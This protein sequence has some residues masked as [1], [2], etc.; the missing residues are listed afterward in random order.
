[1]QKPRQ[2]ENARHGKLE[3][4]LILIIYIDSIYS[5]IVFFFIGL[6][7]FSVFSLARSGR[8]V[9]FYALC[10]HGQLKDLKGYGRLS[11]NFPFYGWSVALLWSLLYL[12]RSR[13]FDRCWYSV[14]EPCHVLRPWRAFFFNTVLLAVMWWESPSS[15]PAPPRELQWYQIGGLP[16]SVDPDT[17][18][19]LRCAKVES[20]WRKSSLTPFAS[21]VKHQK[22]FEVVCLVRRLLRCVD[23][24]ARVHEARAEATGPVSF[25]IFLHLCAICVL[26]T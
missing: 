15:P 14:L 22:Q 4:C 24:L 26:V 13:R 23:W 9:F 25:C 16:L 7:V 8:V 10:I 1:M 11:D 5:E 2:R 3:V 6:L 18:T 20:F 21:T 12:S 17:D 19:W